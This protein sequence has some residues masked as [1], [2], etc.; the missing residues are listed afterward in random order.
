MTVEQLLEP[1]AHRTENLRDS[2][3]HAQIRWLGQQFDPTGTGMS[4]S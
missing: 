4:F 3:R 1:V 2:G